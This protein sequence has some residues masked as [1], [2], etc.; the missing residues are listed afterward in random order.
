M[1][2][3]LCLCERSLRRSH[4]IPEFLYKPLYGAA[5]RALTIHRDLPYIRRIGRGLR[6]RL[7]CGKCEKLIKKYE[8]YFKMRWYDTS[9]LPP[10][11]PIGSNVMV[12]GGLDYEQFK[13][14]HL[15]ILWRASVSSLDEFGEVSL[16]PHEER[17]RRMLLDADAGSIHEYRILATLLLRPGSRIPHSGVMG[18]PERRRLDGRW[19]YTS[20]YAAC[21]WHIFISSH[22]SQ[23]LDLTALKPDGTMMIPMIDIRRIPHLHEQFARGRALALKQP[24]RETAK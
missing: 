12:I 20:V 8:D 7:L 11:V 23:D 10:D 3:A 18:I 6:E 24:L 21:A 17:V 22:A 2:C 13:L 1:N 19:A 14:F 9:P 16:G 4:I 5:H 15:S